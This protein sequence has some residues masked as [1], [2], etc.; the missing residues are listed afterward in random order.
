MSQNSGSN[1]GP[2]V[3]DIRRTYRPVEL[4]RLVGLSAS[5]I[6][7]YE[8]L[9]FI[10]PAR[11]TTAGYRIFDQLHATAVLVARCLQQGYGWQRALNAMQAVHDL[12][13]D[14][15][16]AVADECHASIHEQRQQVT[17]ALQGLDAARRDFGT[18]SGLRVPRGRTISIGQAAS[19][20]GITASAIRY[21]ES[22]GAVTPIRTA[23]GRRRYD[24]L[25]LQRVQLVKLLR[26]INY[27]FD[28]ITEIL[29]GLT[30][31]ASVKARH[32]L[33][34]RQH[35]VEAA[36]LAAARATQTLLTYLEHRQPGQA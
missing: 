11:R 36:S 6:R 21:W 12:D 15:A 10:P 1:L 34:E 30:D 32:A 22:R 8:R 35:R 31:P 33:L 9:G 26:D 25:L 20:L 13:T 14:R 16:L 18:V 19:A 7:N 4:G 24:Q 2:V 5:Q 17:Q 23:D 27:D 3:E 29:H 28:T